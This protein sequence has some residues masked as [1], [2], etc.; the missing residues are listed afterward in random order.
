MPTLVESLRARG[1]EAV[2]AFGEHTMALTLPLETG[3]AT[4]F[5][6]HSVRPAAQSK[7]AQ[8]EVKLQRV[9]FK[10]EKMARTRLEN[11]ALGVHRV[12]QNATA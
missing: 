12:E 5:D 10:Q 6:E 3:A 2:R 8:L 7:A 11:V 4:D 1:I 9:K